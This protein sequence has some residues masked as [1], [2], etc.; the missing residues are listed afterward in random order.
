MISEL[1]IFLGIK[2]IA[3]DIGKCLDIFVEAIDEE[4]CEDN[5]KIDN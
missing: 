4:Y 3:K 1:I 2:S 5:L